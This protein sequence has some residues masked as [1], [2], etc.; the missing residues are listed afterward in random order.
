[1][2]MINFNNTFYLIHYIQ[3]LI[4]PYVQYKMR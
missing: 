1:M 2:G 3:N 4:S